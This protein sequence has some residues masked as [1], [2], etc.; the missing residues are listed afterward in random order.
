MHAQ[1]MPVCGN[2]FHHTVEMILKGGLARKRKLS[3]LKD[4]GHKLKVLWQAYRL[5]P[6]PRAEAPRQDDFRSR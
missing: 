4:M 1:C 3:D 6:R 5:I 2:L